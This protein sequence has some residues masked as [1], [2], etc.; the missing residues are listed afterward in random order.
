MKYSIE[1][2]R[3]LA[4]ILIT[5]THTRHSLTQE[6]TLT[7]FLAEQLPT[8]GTVLLSIVS[9]YLYRKVSFDKP[10]LFFNKVKTLLIPFLI[11]NLLV[12]TLVLAAN[13]IFDINFLNRLSF[14]S[15]L[16]TE[17]VLA[18]NSPPINPPTYFIRDIFMIFVLMEFVR[19]RNLYMLLIIIPLLVFGKL[20]LRYDILLLFLLGMA[21]A[22]YEV[23][24]NPLK[25]KLMIC[26][27]LVLLSVILIAQTDVTVYKY[28]IALLIF[29]LAINWKVKFYNVGSYSYLLHLYHSPIIVATYPV[30]ENITENDFLSVLIQ[31]SISFAVVYLLYRLT[32]KVVA[33]RVLCGYK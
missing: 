9:G 17:G 28:P 26:V 5:L 18:L 29:I 30:I 4:V 33:L 22:H 6:S 27:V 14:D 16:L 11:A 8:I 3:L 2:I 31:V 19:N 13:Y 1:L 12:L 21:I 24:L 7:Y 20:L 15:S 32:R 23:F 10:K 25:T